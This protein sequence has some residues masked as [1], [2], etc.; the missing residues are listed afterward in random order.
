MAIQYYNNYVD[1]T[2]FSDVSPYMALISGSPLTYTVPG[3][4]TMKLQALFSYNCTSNVFVGLNVDPVVPGNDTITTSGRNIELRPK[5]R[6]VQG[7]DVLHFRTPDAVAYVG[8]SFR[9]L[10]QGY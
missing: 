8:V 9:L 5:K 1:T 3:D 7:G 6:F 4:A 10:Q 2:T